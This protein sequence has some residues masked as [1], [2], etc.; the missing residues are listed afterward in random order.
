MV[1]DTLDTLGETEDDDIEE[2]AQEEID[3]I[4]M[5]VTDSKLKHTVEVPTSELPAVP[6]EQEAEVE[7][8]DD[9]LTAMREQMKSLRS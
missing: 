1:G 9:L 7:E 6:S 5:E 2:A 8:D 4:L 3:K